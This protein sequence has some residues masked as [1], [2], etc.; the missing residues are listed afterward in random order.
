MSLE[1]ENASDQATTRK[2]R[3]PFFILKLIFILTGFVL[4]IFT[5]MANMGG[6]SETLKGSIENFAG[7]ATGYLAQI[8]KLNNMTFFPNII[9]DFEGM[10]LYD[11]ANM[12][13]VAYV[14]KFQIALS[15]WDVMFSNG[16]IK[17][18]NVEE[19][20]ALPGVL[21][22]KRVSAQRI[23]IEETVDGPR[24]RGE[25]FV[26]DEAFRF[27]LSMQSEGEGRNRKFMFGDK[28]D[29][30][31]SL[32]GIILNFKIVP[33]K[34]AGVIF[35]DI[36]ISLDDKK[37]AAGHLNVVRNAER[38]GITGKIHMSGGHQT[39]LQPEVEMFVENGIEAVNGKIFSQ[40][41]H[42]DDFISGS[43][44][45]SLMTELEKTL[46]PEDPE[47]IDLALEAEQIYREGKDQ[48]AYTGPLPL[49]GLRIDAENIGAGQ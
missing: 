30:Y 15:F 8:E 40:Q 22:N 6:S 7:E 19:V 13:P 48:G 5:V 42:I 32:A 46:A 14:G 37:I 16:K 47:N 31:L 49:K 28:R 43:D 41:F 2:R 27:S 25:G 3:W 11:E 38:F 18:L 45:D 21:L 44:Y 12:L 33:G 23:S 36:E 1:T 4:V 24:F 17:N 29:F 26:G 35:Q 10:Q 9:F 34:S 39:D 20:R